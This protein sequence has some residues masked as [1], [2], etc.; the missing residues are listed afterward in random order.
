MVNTNSQKIILKLEPNNIPIYNDADFSKKGI[1][2]LKISTAALLGTGLLQVIIFYISGSAALLADTIHNFSDAFT[3]IPLWIAFVLSLRKPTR[4]LTY[5]YGRVEDAAG[6][7]IILVIL[8][9]GI[10][11]LYE[12]VYKLIN[13]VNI[14]NTNWVM[15]AGIIGFIGNELAAKY[16]IKT[17]KEI[18]SISLV[19]DGKHSRIDGITS[20]GVL[21]GAIGVKIGLPIIDPMAGIIISIFIFIILIETSKE[22]FNRLLDVVDPSLLTDIEKIALNIPNVKGVSDVKARWSGH[23]IYTEI[24]ITVA[25]NI[26]VEDGHSIAMNV[27]RHLIQ[28]IAHLKNI[29]I[30]VDPQNKIGEINH[31]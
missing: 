12:S 10:I 27:H 23:K 31:M 13:P 28:K 4:S 8:I 16:R 5:G 25:N 22:I 24:S 9:S 18:N 2:A 21:V 29:T 30:H 15:A 19:A 6:L 20:L 17:G 26:S 7:I 3:A 1:K 14:T 11:A